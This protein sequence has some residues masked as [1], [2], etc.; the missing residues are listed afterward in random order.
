MSL[1]QKPRWQP[2]GVYVHWATVIVAVLVTL[3][4]LSYSVY[5][6]YGVGWTGLGKSSVKQGVEPA[7]TLWEWLGLLI[8]PVMLA[9]G[10][11]LI[12]RWQKDRDDKFQQA[13]KQREEMVALQRAQDEALRAYLDQMSDLMVDRELRRKLREETEEP[14]EHRI[15]QARTLAILLGL[16]KDRKRLPLKLIYELSLIA[17]EEPILNLKNAGLDTADL[18]EITLHDACLREADLRRANLRG[19]DLR[20]SDL[21]GADLRGADLRETDLSNTLLIGANLLPYDEKAPAKLNAPNL[22]NGTEPSDVDL[23]NNHLVP[24]NLEDANLSDADLSGAYLTGTKVT[25]EQLASSASLRGATMPDG[26]KH[27]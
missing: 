27:V 12:N 16:D 19:A 5:L 13:Q 24:T 21:T 18:S 15:A 25:S 11:Y 14:D 3:V 22:S 17:K 8:V 7:K 10:G 4:I 26:T 2:T 23:S 20:G 9:V 1:E 6:G